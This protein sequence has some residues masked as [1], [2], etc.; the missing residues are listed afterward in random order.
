[1][2]KALTVVYAI[3]QA[4]ANPEAAAAMGANTGFDLTKI[5]AGM[6]V[7]TLISSMP[8]AQVQQM[9]S[10]VNEKFSTMDDKMIT[11][12]AAAA[13]K[14]EY[15]ALGMDTAKVQSAYIWRIGGIMI[16][17]TLLSVAAI[18]AVGLLSSRTAAGVARDLRRDIFTKVESFA[19]PSLKNS[20]PPR[21]S[22]VQPTMSPSCK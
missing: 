13:I 20:P 17:V 22:P 18:I 14:A 15:T 16:L 7:F 8:A 9:T 3:Q 6:D 10:S 2:G 19:K 12:A 21:S 5:P 1:M 4:A 11:Q